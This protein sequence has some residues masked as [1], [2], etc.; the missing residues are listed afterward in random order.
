MSNLN[1]D[2]NFL[3]AH[4][5]FDRRIVRAEGHYL[6][7][8]EGKSYLDCLAQYGALPFGHNPAFLWAALDKARSAYEP[9]MVQP[10]ISPAAEELAAKLVEISPCDEGYV[11]FANSGAEAVESAI[12]LA[13]S[14][15]QR[16]VIT[17]RIRV[18]TAR[19]SAPCR[20]PEP[21][22]TVRRFSSIP[23]TSPIFLMATWRHWKSGSAALTS[24]AS[25]SNRYKG[26]QA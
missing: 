25:S 12:K 14:K 4:I 5:G 2:R 17:V 16:P 6:F 26:R 18:S 1:P 11:T 23:R 9:S 13:R 8:S 15:T 3:L 19:R 20:P 22:N 10:L 21:Q 24:P 7:D